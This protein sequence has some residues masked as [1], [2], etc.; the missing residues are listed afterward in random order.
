MVISPISSSHIIAVFGRHEDIPGATDQGENTPSESSK[1]ESS[2]D[3]LS[4]LKHSTCDLP[5]AIN[6]TPVEERRNEAQFEEWLYQHDEELHKPTSENLILEKDVIEENS[7]EINCQSIEE[8]IP[9]VDS[10]FSYSEEEEIVCVFLSPLQIDEPSCIDPSM[11]LKLEEMSLACES[12]SMHSNCVSSNN[13]LKEGRN[14]I[15]LVFQSNEVT[16]HQLVDSMV[17]VT[18][19]Y[20]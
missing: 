19:S 4:A 7:P 16:N 10:T 2:D 1:E 14:A 17:K 15:D 18:S 12:P 20:T 9:L 5:I 6:L 8:S 3:H 11:E 13:T